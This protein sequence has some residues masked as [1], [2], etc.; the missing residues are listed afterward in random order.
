MTLADRMHLVHAPESPVLRVDQI[1]KAFGVNAVIQDVSFELRSKQILGIIGPSGGGKTTLLKCLDLL[2]AADNGSVEYFNRWK[3]CAANGSR[4]VCETGKE[5]R[6]ELRDA[7]I[8]AIR[9]RMGFVFQS[10]NLWEDR[11]VLGNLALAPMVVLKMPPAEA[12][13]RALG[14]CKRFGLGD[15]LEQKVWQLSG[16]QRQRVAIIRALMMEPEILLLDEVTSALDP[17]L[18]FDVLETIRELRQRGLTM[19]LVT[20]HLEFASSVCDRLMFLAQ[21]RVLQL[22]TPEQLR[23][24]PVT[25][26]IRQYLEIL[27]AAR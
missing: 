6:E 19:I 12:A 8:Y 15:K 24:Q 20:H 2:E 17:V 13:E 21:G 22:D 3:V 10:F 18:T 16:G 23:Q 27:R 14:L 4:T 5:I 26:D 1:S 25:P 11:S 9:R 7:H